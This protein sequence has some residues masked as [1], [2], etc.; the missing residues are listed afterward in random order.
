MGA[1]GGTSYISAVRRLR[2]P[3]VI[4]AAQAE[5]H[6]CSCQKIIA[7]PRIDA[8]AGT[9]PRTTATPT[10]IKIYAAN[11]E[12]ATLVFMLPHKLLR[13]HR[14]QHKKVLHTRTADNGT[15][16]ST[17]G[18]YVCFWTRTYAS[19]PFRISL[20]RRPYARPHKATGDSPSCQTKMLRLAKRRRRTCF[21]R[22]AVTE[23]LRT[24]NKGKIET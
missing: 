5:A 22:K 10:E 14:R 16:S 1:K 6:K 17:Q 11:R 2:S 15:P 12:D 4:T 18:R 19:K 3:T 9:W 21:T 13:F 7:A 8:D 24:K 20:R 23:T